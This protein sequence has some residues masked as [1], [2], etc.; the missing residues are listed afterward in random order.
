[1][2][3]TVGRGCCIVP[4]SIFFLVKAYNLFSIKFTLKQIFDFGNDLRLN[5]VGGHLMYASRTCNMH[6]L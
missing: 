4:T 3:L 6:I 2:H 1:M 5:I